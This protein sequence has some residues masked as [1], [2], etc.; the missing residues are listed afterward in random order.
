M[1]EIIKQINDLAEFVSE[2][3]LDEWIVPKLVEHY[4]NI[5]RSLAGRAYGA[6]AVYTDEGPTVALKAFQEMAKKEIRK[7]VYTFIFKSEHWRTGRDINTYL[8]KSINRLA[9]RIKCNSEST[10]KI[11]ALVCPGC[12][13]LS[14]KVILEPFGDFWKCPECSDALKRID[15]EIK[16]YS[17]KQSDEFIMRLESKSRLYKS[18]SIHSRR[19]YR[20]P[21]CSRFIPESCN[22]EHGITCPYPDCFYIGTVDELEKI[23][24]PV[25]LLKQVNLR[26]RSSC[27]S[28]DPN[29]EDMLSADNLDADIHISVNESFKEELSLLKEV[30]QQQLKTVKRTN[31]AGT[32]MQK[33]LMYEA[34][35]NI[36]KSYPEDMISYL[37]HQKQNADFPLQSKIFQEYVGLMYDALPYTINRNGQEHEVVSLLD[38]KISLFEGISEFDAVVKSNH[39]I[40]NNTKECYIGGRKFKNYGPCFIGRVIEIKD[41]TTNASIK[42]HMIDHSFVQIKMNK[43][44]SPGTPVFV[45]HYR[46]ASH[47]EMGSL[48]YLQRVRKKIVDKVYLKI[49]KKPRVSVS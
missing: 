23:P 35:D 15:N 36:I 17:K 43:E 12:I 41:K 40:P 2:N 14:N 46:I 5:I 7:A 28:D 44:V 4:D 32:M 37:V 42:K 13:Y 34:Y 38:P 48:V 45:K 3:D 24:H 8:L 9:D 21:D 19:G 33:V 22:G 30:I 39:T 26:L 6:A 25:C 31:S 27:S 49:H 1:S 10:K 47:Y 16:T 18:F 11:N 29:I 20:C